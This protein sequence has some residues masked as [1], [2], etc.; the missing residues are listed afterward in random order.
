M[1]TVL[2]ITLREALEIAL[3]IGVILRCLVEA[4]QHHF[5][6]SL[7]YGVLLGLAGSVLGG[8][9]FQKIAGGFSGTGA[10]VFKV[11]TELGGAVLIALVVV[12]MLKE[13]GGAQKLKQQALER[14]EKEEKWGIFFLAF[15]SVLREGV[16]L[17]V[18]LLVAGV[19]DSLRDVVGVMVGAVVAIAIGYVVYRGSKKISLRKFFTVTSV[20]LLL[21]AAN[22]IREGVHGLERAKVVPQYLLFTPDS[23]ESVTRAEAPQLDDDEEDEILENLSLLQFVVLAAYGGTLWYALKKINKK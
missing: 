1:L 9:L 16:E 20:L 14:L 21:F 2:F 19:N 13:K 22:L 4:N 7:V 8:W 23:K 15:I 6:K 11:V 18:Y 17:V 10:L 5:K 3:I 12:W